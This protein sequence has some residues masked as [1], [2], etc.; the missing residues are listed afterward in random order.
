M[1]NKDSQLKNKTSMLKSSLRDYSDTFILVK[2]TISIKQVLA[3]AEPDDVGKEV[4]FKN[5]APFTDFTS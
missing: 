5:C 3:P 4:V 2:G 1:Y